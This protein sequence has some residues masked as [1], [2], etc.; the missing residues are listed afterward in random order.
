MR[1][2]DF[3]AFDCL[4]DCNLEHEHGDCDIPAIREIVGRQNFS[5]EEPDWSKMFGKV[6]CDED[7]AIRIF[8]LQ[9]PTVETYSGIDASD[10]A[11]PG[12]KAAH[13][14]QLDHASRQGLRA[15]GYEDQHCWVPPFC[16]AFARRMQKYFGWVQSSDP[17]DQWL[18]LVRKI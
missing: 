13:F 14:E 11:T 16:R 1:V 9:R 15:R 3:R 7:G 8:E 2:R 10:W 17:A 5:Y 4:P 6:S 18:G 12:L